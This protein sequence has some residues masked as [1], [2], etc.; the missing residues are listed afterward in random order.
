[1]RL[2]TDGYLGI[3]TNNPYRRCHIKEGTWN[4]AGA[5]FW[6]V[7][8]NSAGTGL[9]MRRTETSNEAG[10]IYFRYLYDGT[11]G[12]TNHMCF[13]VIQ[14]T[15]NAEPFAAANPHMTIRHDGNVGIGT[16]QP[17]AKLAVYG[18]SGGISS[19]NI[20]YFRYNT[21]HT[22]SSTSGTWGGVGIWAQ[23]SIASQDYIVS[24][25]GNLTS[26]DERIKKNIVDADDAECLE[27]LRLLKPKKYQ[28]R[29]VV[30]KGEEPV[31]GF[32][33]QEVRDTLPYAT[34]LRKDVL[35]NIYELANVSSSNVI[36]FTDFN[37]SNLESNATTLIRTTGIDGTQ[38]DV[39]LA[40]VIDAHSIRVKEDL[41]DF[42][43]SLDAEGN[44]ISEITTTTITPE[45]YEALGDK[46]GYV[47]NIS[48]YQNANVSISVEEYNALEDTT[49]YEQVV[50]DYT[51]T[52]T[53]Y[54]GNQLF[55]VGQEVDDFVFLKKESI[56][57]VATAALQEVD[58]QLQAEKTK[59]ATLETQVA[60]LLARVTALENA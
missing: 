48:G 33:A 43:G 3:G 51:K 16:N 41:T 49:G 4:A 6:I 50:Q 1:M 37:T 11:I 56:F 36:T 45:E 25:Q 44:V 20:R 53:T 10:S 5:P 40:E 19:S 28:Y 2:T 18:N 55:V 12:G 22:S 32:I 59:T 8:N 29:D 13:H 46:T 60:A 30:E 24:H 54:P 39:H 42:S 9:T 23:W 58:R 15:P 14:S 34:Q 31:W 7:K 26:S 52:S 27:T 21:D 47:A 38:H 17:W 57:T 35:P